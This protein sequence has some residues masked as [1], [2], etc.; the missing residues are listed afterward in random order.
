MKKVIILICVILSLTSGCA[1]LSGSNPIVTEQGVVLSNSLSNTIRTMKKIDDIYV[2]INEIVDIEHKAKTINSKDY[3][4]IINELHKFKT[5][6]VEATI[7]VDRWRDIETNGLPLDIEKINTKTLLNQL[8]N[9][10]G[11]LS[12]IKGIKEEDVLRVNL[13]IRLITR[14]SGAE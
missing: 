14:F 11:A 5:I 8:T 10:T 3:E 12:L 1:I 4:T 6:Y 9:L 13:A 2:I 7:I